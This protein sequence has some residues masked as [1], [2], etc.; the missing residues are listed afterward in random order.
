MLK[1]TRSHA[2]W[3]LNS[4]RT[5]SFEGA[6]EYIVVTC[7]RFTEGVGAGSA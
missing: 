3:H 7:V 4:I 2:P 6:Y 5:F 1:V